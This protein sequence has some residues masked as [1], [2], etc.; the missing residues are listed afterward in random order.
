MQVVGNPRSGKETEE[1]VPPTI[2]A[3][4][5]PTANIGVGQ[6]VTFLVRTCRTTFGREL[7]D[8]GDGTA[9]VFALSDGC[10]VEKAANGY[11]KVQ[12]AFRKPGDY[13]VKVANF[14]DEM[15]VNYYQLSPFYSAKD[16]HDLIGHMVIGLAPHTSGGVLCPDHAHD[17]VV[18]FCE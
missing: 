7:W 8:F 11:A 6:P 15:L 2:H 10:A 13:L 3:S 16:R 9:P 14:I 12:H 5:W 1:Q 17:P 4:F 18:L